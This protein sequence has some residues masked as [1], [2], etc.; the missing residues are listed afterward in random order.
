VGS[1]AGAACGV[2]ICCGAVDLRWEVE[3]LRGAM[4]GVDLGVK[5]DGAID[6]SMML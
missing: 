5:C 1:W 6:G 3:R 4:E 2:R